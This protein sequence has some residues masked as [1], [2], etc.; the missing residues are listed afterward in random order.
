MNIPRPFK[1]FVNVYSKSKIAKTN[2]K[3]NPNDAMTQ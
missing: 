3:L 2:S 1:V